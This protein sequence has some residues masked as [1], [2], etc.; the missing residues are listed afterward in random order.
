MP[1]KPWKVAERRVAEILGGER[2]AV[3]GR[4]RGHAP[5]IEHPALSLEVKSR[6]SIP[7]WLTE[8][9]E[10][11]TASSRDDKLPVAVLHAAGRQYADALV[12]LRLEDLADYLSKPDTKGRRQ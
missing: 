6:K 5:D 11:A 3:S 1:D 9:L 4:V 10:Q 7:A 8:A 12:V 2:I